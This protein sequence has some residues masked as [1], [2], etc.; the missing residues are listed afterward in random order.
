MVELP[1][2]QHLDEASVES[3]RVQSKALFGNR[4][5][6]E[7]AVAIARA[8]EMFYVR[9]LSKATRIPEPQIKAIVAAIESD[10]GL[11]RRLDGKRGSPQFYER[12]KSAYWRA[13]EAL[14]G[15]LVGSAATQ[16]P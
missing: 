4:H 16:G 6:L 3:L 8:D 11:L 13:A 1:L 2:D 9:E 5:R 7:V 12:R 14:F 15:E 10:T